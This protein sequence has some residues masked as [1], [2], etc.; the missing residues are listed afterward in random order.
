[1]TDTEHLI[2]PYVFVDTQAFVANRLDWTGIQLGKLASLCSAG[3]LK[4]LMPSITR[5]EVIRKIEEG[6]DEAIEQTKKH[7]IALGNSGLNLEPLGD[8]Q[9][10][11]A[12]AIKRFDLFLSMA[13]ATD[14]PIQVSLEAVLD[15]YFN[16]VPPFSKRKGK[17]KEFPDAFVGASLVAWL[18]RHGERA[19]VVSA[20]GDFL[21]F[22]DR[23]HSLIYAKSISEVISRANVSEETRAALA[24]K[25]QESRVLFE[26]LEEELRHLRPPPE[27][28][29]GRRWPPG[30][31][32]RGR[33]EV[34]SARVL[35][36]TDVNVIDSSPPSYACE[37]EFEAE[38][39]I[40]A[41]VLNET[42]TTIEGD[43]QNIA[44]ERS[45]VA[46]V[47]LLFGPSADDVVIEKIHDLADQLVIRREDL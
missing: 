36:I 39:N 45:F 47:E 22:C 1:M 35:G 14:V 6:L 4:L 33:S 46:I 40:R 3:T 43:A 29:L 19:Y 23:H 18:C 8:R 10:L 44:V 15:D 2:T 37:I 16:V 9:K 26:K 11:L 20:D 31:W 5:R 12:E 13:Q 42:D 32:V 24:R 25:V 7:R 21:E 27:R 30:L 17:E 28:G 34:T 41:M 38:L